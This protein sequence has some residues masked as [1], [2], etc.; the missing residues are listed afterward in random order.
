MKYEF[1][2]NLFHN[3]ELI[4]YFGNYNKIII[5]VFNYNNNRIIV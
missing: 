1:T 5:N 2:F 3:R 4:L